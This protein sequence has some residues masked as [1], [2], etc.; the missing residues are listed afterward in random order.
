M[1]VQSYLESLQSAET[2]NFDPKK[3]QEQQ[4]KEEESMHPLAFRR[5]AKKIGGDHEYQN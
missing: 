5:K 2:T 3:S 4:E 1:Q